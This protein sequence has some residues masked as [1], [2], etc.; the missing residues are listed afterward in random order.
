MPTGEA[1]AAQLWPEVV[2]VIRNAKIDVLGQDDIKNEAHAD[3]VR[4]IVSEF[5]DCPDGFIYIEPCTIRSTRRPADVV[6][7]HPDY[8]VIVFE[9]K[10]YHIKDIDSVKA[11]SLMIRQGG[12]IKPVN[13]YN[14]AMTVMFDIKNQVERLLA[15]AAE[16]PP[17]NFVVVLP[18]VPRSEWLR[19]CFQDQVPTEELLLRDD[20]LPGTLVGRLRRLVERGSRKRPLTVSQ[21]DILRKAF[22]DSASINSDRAPRHDVPE[23]TLGG[24]IDELAVNEKYLSAEQNELSRLSICGFPRLVRGVAGSGKTIVLANLVARLLNRTQNQT[25]QLFHELEDHHLRV[26][27]VCFNRAL[28]PFLREKIGD[29]YRQQ[30]FETL[31]KHGILTTTHLNGLMNQVVYKRN[32]LH[33]ISIRD[34]PEP[35]QRAL[36]YRKQLATYKEHD[37]HEYAA[38]LFDAVFVD[39]GQDFDPL[40]FELLLDL[41]KTNEATG[42]KNLIIFYDDAQN[43]YARSRPN[44]KQLGIDVQRGDRARVMKE[45]FRNTRE[46]IGL[47]FNVLLG[48]QA[49][50][51]NRVNL[52]SFADV[53]YLKKAEL[54]KEG[55]DLYEVGFAERTG[56][57]PYLHSFKSRTL[58]KEWV[59]REIGTLI[60]REKVRPEDILILFAQHHEFEDLPKYIRKDVEAKSVV[61]FLC[62]F[63]D[64]PDRDKY[65]FEEN[66]LTL[67]TVHGAKGYDA[68]I[69]FVVG[70]DLFKPDEKGRAAFYVGATRAKLLL[71]VSGLENRNDLL[72]EC[73]AIESLLAAKGPAGQVSRQ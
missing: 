52:K 23:L 40:E 46:I 58:E 6:L 12:I 16:T 44:W 7:C 21:F 56:D 42:E 57:A 4:A 62:P 10:G 9:V 39:E 35:A 69:V 68:P 41:I 3:V 49:P 33:S 67:S 73:L 29:S 71:H 15:N 17:F 55:T 26:A 47:A 48:S 27:V 51:E 5:T 72:K 19:K 32:G 28:V 25:P 36:L 63:G 43:L 24:Y 30:T 11:G 31:P 18:N 66:H 20:L 2:K 53:D 22:G 61:D 34:V 54:I 59:A 37:P 13:A 65:I 70:A 45:C 60:N 1:T 50:N 8:G 14:Q 64:S 38:L